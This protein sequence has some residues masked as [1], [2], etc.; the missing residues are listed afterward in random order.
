MEELIRVTLVTFDV[1]YFGS[2]DML[3]LVHAMSTPGMITQLRHT[4]GLPSLT[5]VELL[6]FRISA[7]PLLS[8]S[9]TAP[10]L[11]QDIAAR[12]GALT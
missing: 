4:N 12:I 1:M 7:G 2:D 8:V 9:S 3:A 6:D 5:V 10:R 11:D